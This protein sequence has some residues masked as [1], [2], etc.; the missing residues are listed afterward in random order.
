MRSAFVNDDDDDDDHHHHHCYEQTMADYRRA[1]MDNDD[2]DADSDD[3]RPRVGGMSVEEIQEVVL[4]QHAK[5]KDLQKAMDEAES[6]A[7]DADERAM[8]LDADI[9]KLKMQSKLL[10]DSLNEVTEASESWKAK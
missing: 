7:D 8:L 6:R 2:D 10:R 1:W 9:V 4:L 3:D 5:I